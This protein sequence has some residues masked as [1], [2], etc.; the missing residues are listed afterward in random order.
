MKKA[1]QALEEKLLQCQQQ[2]GVIQVQRRALERGWNETNREMA[3]VF[4]RLLDE[5]QEKKRWIERVRDGEESLTLS[6]SSDETNTTDG[7]ASTT[8]TSKT[9][10]TSASTSNASVT[11]RMV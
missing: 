10:S 1:V 5:F 2:L 3:S 6:Q 9:P 7:T 4:C 11:E 8:S